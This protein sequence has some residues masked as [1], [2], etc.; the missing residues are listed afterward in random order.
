MKGIKEPWDR[1]VGRSLVE[2]FERIGLGTDSAI[3]PLEHDWNAEAEEVD[4]D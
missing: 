1:Q 2:K 4:L 3:T